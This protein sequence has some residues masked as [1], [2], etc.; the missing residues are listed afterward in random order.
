MGQCDVSSRFARS[1]RGPG[2][3]VLLTVTGWML[4]ATTSAGCSNGRL[5]TDV[6]CSTG[7]LFSLPSYWPEGTVKVERCVNR[8]CTDSGNAGLVV[9]VP[10]K[11]STRITSASVR[12]LTKDGV[13]TL[14]ATY[15]GSLRLTKVEP[16][17][18]RC[19]PTCYFARFRL[20]PDGQLV[21]VSVDTR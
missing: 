21:P 7:V 16:N 5:C 18:A 11:P 12:F 10:L 6:G 1:L 15:A 13:A 14:S 9:E 20:T 4:L 8:R 2:A 17:G 3:A 19:G